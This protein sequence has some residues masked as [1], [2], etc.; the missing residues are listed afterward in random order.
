[1]EEWKGHWRQ[2]WTKIT[3]VHLLRNCSQNRVLVMAVLVVVVVVV[4]MMMTLAVKVAISHQMGNLR[5]TVHLVMMSSHQVLPSH[6]RKVMP[7]VR[8]TQ[9][10][11]PSKSV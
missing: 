4:V 6:A 1:M 8:K 11:P 3:Q 5:V 2:E 7:Q 9:F 10:N